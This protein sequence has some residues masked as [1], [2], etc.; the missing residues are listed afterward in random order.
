MFAHSYSNLSYHERATVSQR[1]IPYGE[2][3]FHAGNCTGIITRR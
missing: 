1:H 2:V 3:V